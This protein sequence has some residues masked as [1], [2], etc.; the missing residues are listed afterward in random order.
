M[1]AVGS[2]QEEDVLAGFSP[3]LQVWP[4]GTGIKTFVLRRGQKVSNTSPLN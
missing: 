3:R 1:E 2:S 4:F